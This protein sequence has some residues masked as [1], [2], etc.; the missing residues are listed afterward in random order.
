[1][2]IPHVCAISDR[3]GQSRPP[4][5]PHA[6]MA[7]EAAPGF[8]GPLLP[9]GGNATHQSISGYRAASNQIEIAESRP[10][11]S[12][13]AICLQIPRHPSK[14]EMKTRLKALPHP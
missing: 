7:A 2:A 12:H 11:G 1:M 10:V 3:R 6:D 4:L 13:P 5:S 8:N 9:Q 14:A